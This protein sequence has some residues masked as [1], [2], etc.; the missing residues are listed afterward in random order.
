VKYLLL[1]ALV[2]II[3]GCENK[4]TFGTKKY[5]KILKE[6]REKASQFILTC[7]KNA[8]PMSDEEGEDLVKQCQRT[9]EKIFGTV[10]FGFCYGIGQGC[11]ESETISCDDA[12]M[13]HEIE[14]CKK[15]GW[16]E[17]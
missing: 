13:S 1:I 5:T 15:I 8:N 7:A 16:R 6:D 12:K 14:A 9:A 4:A 10:V 2:F 3:Q 11:W 17:K